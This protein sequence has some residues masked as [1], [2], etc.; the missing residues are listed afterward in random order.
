MDWKQGLT[1]AVVVGLGYL[2][3][4]NVTKGAESFS[5]PYPRKYGDYYNP[6]NDCDG[7]VMEDQYQRETT[8]TRHYCVD[9]DRGKSTC[10]MDEEWEETEESYAETDESFSAENRCSVCGAS[11]HNER[12]CPY[13]PDTSFTT[14][15]PRTLGIMGMVAVIAGGAYIWTQRATNGGKQDE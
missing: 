10:G 13:G 11:S 5:A 12:S 9:S 3:F 6:C 15:L 1:A 8:Y 2:G 14:N 7:D 4:Q